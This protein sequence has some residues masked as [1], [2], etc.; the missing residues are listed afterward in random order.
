MIIL[1]IALDLSQSLG[2]FFKFKTPCDADE[3]TLLETQQI[4]HVLSAKNAH[5]YAQKAVILTR[6]FLLIFTA[7]I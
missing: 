5:T 4:N 6:V 1:S 2:I 7:P 3:D